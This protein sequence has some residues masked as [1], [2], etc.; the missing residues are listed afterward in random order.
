MKILHLKDLQSTW[1]NDTLIRKRDV[2]GLTSG[3]SK[4]EKQDYHSDVRGKG[5]NFTRGQTEFLVIIEDTIN[6]FNPTSIDGTVEDDPVLLLTLV[7][8]AKTK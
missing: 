2:K 5:E 6:G 7:L 1:M 4:S 8:I 3:S